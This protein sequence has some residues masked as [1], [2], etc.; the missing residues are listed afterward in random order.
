MPKIRKKHEVE[1]LVDKGMVSVGRGEEKHSMIQAGLAKKIYNMYH[2]NLPL[3]YIKKNT[4]L[5]VLIIKR[6]I[7]KIKEAKH[8]NQYC[9][10]WSDSTK[11]VWQMLRKEELPNNCLRITFASSNSRGMWAKE[12]S[13]EKHVDKCNFEFWS[14][15]LNAYILRICTTKEA[16]GD[17]YE[18]LPLEEILDN[19]TVLFQQS[20]LARN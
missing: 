20:E 12:D 2:E 9:R 16:F 15:D 6:T 7:K 19:R 11:R 4:G 18:A 14:E 1:K 8:I 10:P 3:S 13:H 17:K 5:P